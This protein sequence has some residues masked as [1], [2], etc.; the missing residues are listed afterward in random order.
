M[1][2]PAYNWLVQSYRCA[3]KLLDR[4]AH[5]GATG[6]GPTLGAAQGTA[7]PRPACRPHFVWAGGA[8]R[9]HEHRAHLRQ[10]PGPHTAGAAPQL[11]CAAGAGMSGTGAGSGIIRRP[12]GIAS[13]R[14]VAAAASCRRQPGAAASQA[15]LPA[16]P[17]A[18]KAVL[19]VMVSSCATLFLTL[20]VALCFASPVCRHPCSATS[21][22]SATPTAPPGD[23]R[24]A[25][26]RAVRRCAPDASSR[27]VQK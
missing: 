25:A 9:D 3:E 7:G 23:E 26:A 13:E 15:V 5:V 4:P 6:C 22:G 8:A 1:R 16:Q 21:M 14:S 27:V 11:Y 19:P 24:C 20:I 18:G 12:S 2:A 17:F 10:K